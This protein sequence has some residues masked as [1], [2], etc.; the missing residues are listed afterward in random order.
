M[1]ES[2]SR[3]T[4]PPA[5][6]QHWPSDEDLAAYIDGNLG[7]AESKRITEHLASCEE[8]YAV[9]MGALRFQID[10]SPAA[11]EENVVP[12]RG[13][14]K[15]REGRKGQEGQ[16]IGRLIVRWG[17]LAAA[18][19]VGVGAGTYVQLLRPLPALVTAE[20]S[21]PIPGRPELVQGFWL[22]PT[23]RGEGGEEEG[24]APDTAALRTGVHLVN[25]QV[26]L[27]AG[28]VRESQDVIARILGL[29]KDQLFADDLQSDYAK[30]TVAVEKRPPSELLPE[31][32]R[33]A[34]ETRKVF[35]G[36]TDS[37]DLGQW[38]EG[39]RLAA[40]SR[41]PSFFR[42]GET[43]GFLRRLLWRDK[44][45]WGEMT[46]DP[47]TRA[48]LQEI[49]QTLARGDLGATDYKELGVQFDE[50]LKI[51]YPES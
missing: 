29:L 7:R 30:L 33:L 3:D 20:V 5:L 45:G 11:P 6:S 13:R 15:G 28:Q 14:G 31:A 46:L 18:L 41:D 40:L 35:E 48:S 22:G 37:L 2:K 42:Q 44:L 16:E 23:L 26:S 24:A 51:H 27:K 36:G 34:E 49:S 39:G 10:S 50:I 19:L 43:R 47:P 9:Y 1:Q 38:V 8:C 25:L 21:R 12:F 4:T 17:S 32:S